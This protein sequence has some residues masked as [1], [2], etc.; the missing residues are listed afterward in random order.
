MARRM[1]NGDVMLGMTRMMEMMGSMGGMMGGDGG[2][3][4]SAPDHRTTPQ[5]TQ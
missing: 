3:K 2:M 4:G 1:G 5:K